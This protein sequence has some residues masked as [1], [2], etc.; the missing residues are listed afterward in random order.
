MAKWRAPSGS[1]GA[2]QAQTLKFVVF[3]LAAALVLSACAEPEKRI[4]EAPTLVAS[5]SPTPLPK[6][7]ATPSLISPT[8][9]LAPPYYSLP[10]LSPA[11]ADYV[12]GGLGIAPLGPAV[13]P[14]GPQALNLT[15]NAWVEKSKFVPLETLHTRGTYELAIDLALFG[16]KHQGAEIETQ[17]PVTA[18][19]KQ[20]IAKQLAD[21]NQDTAHATLVLLPDP[22]HFQAVRNKDRTREISIDLAEIA[23]GAQQG[24]RGTR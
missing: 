24:I 14:S 21:L 3:L 5:A 9:T 16:Y 20:V 10:P 15:W 17:S 13:Y 2:G 7:T 18:Q 11:N 22:A 12:I 1:V 23:S 6:A 8:F 4:L 19:F